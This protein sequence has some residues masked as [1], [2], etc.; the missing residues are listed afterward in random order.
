MHLCEIFRQ[1]ARARHNTFCW[2][3]RKRRSHKSSDIV[4]NAKAYIGNSVFMGFTLGWIEYLFLLGSG[5]E[6]AALVRKP[7]IIEEMHG[8]PTHQHQRF[9]LSSLFIC[10]VMLVVM[11]LFRYMLCVWRKMYWHC[12]V[13]AALLGWALLLFS[14]DDSISWAAAAWWQGFSR[15]T[16]VKCDFAGILLSCGFCWRVNYNGIS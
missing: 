14:V 11:D 4:F 2:H 9:D 10:V 3:H 12:G 6:L 7:I 15:L 8:R 13:P 5:I 16:C 1:F